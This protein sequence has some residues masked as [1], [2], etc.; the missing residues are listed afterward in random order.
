[1]VFPS[2]KPFAERMLAA[3]LFRALDKGRLKNLANLEPGMM[4]TLAAAD[5]DNAH[6]VPYMWGTTGLGYNAAKIKAALGPA[7]PVD[8]WALLFDPGNAQK[9]A[10]CGASRGIAITSTHSTAPSLGTA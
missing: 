9:L 8:S 1:M 5:P 2:L 6:L 10:G 3:K 4:Q 7:A